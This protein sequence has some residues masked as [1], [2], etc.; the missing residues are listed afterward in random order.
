MKTSGGPV[1]EVNLC[2]LAIDFG[3]HVAVWLAA[4]EQ[5][6]QGFKNFSKNLVLFSS[7]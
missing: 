2:S 3:E 6:R 5:E 1:N 4:H 7:P